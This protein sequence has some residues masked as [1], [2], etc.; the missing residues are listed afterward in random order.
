MHRSELAQVPFERREI[1]LPDVERQKDTE[2]KLL[3]KE[4]RGY[5]RLYLHRMS[6]QS[7]ID[8]LKTADQ[9]GMVPVAEAAICGISPG[10][11]SV[12]VSTPGLAN[13]T[14]DEI[15]KLGSTDRSSFA[16]NGVYI[17]GTRCRLIRDQMDLDPVYALDLKTA[18]DAE[19]NTFG[20]CVGKS[21][22]GETLG[23]KGTD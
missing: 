16:Q 23:E 20:V 10:Q 19:G 5:P 7:Y 1:L 15:K 13:I 6:W 14:P 8:T 18:A 9:S 17:G 22:T 4:T 11:E 2:D 3:D 12:W 21:K